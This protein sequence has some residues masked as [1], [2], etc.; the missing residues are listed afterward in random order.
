ML[1]GIAPGHAIKTQ[2]FGVYHALQAKDI[3]SE[4]PCK[5]LRTYQ[6]ENALTIECMMTGLFLMKATNLPSSEKGPLPF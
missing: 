6:V 3:R 4:L 1:G 2:G 5:D